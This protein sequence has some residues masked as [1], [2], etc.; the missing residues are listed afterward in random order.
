MHVKHKAPED[1]QAQKQIYNKM[2]VP[3]KDSVPR[4]EAPIYKILKD[5]PKNHNDGLH[6]VSFSYVDPS[7][8]KAVIRDHSKVSPKSR[9]YHVSPCVLDETECTFKNREKARQ[10][11]Q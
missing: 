3:F 4:T 7:P 5:I 10:V 11:N 1:I 6:R 2:Q 8:K 9:F